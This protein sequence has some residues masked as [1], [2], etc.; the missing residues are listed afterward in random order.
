VVLVNESARNG[1]IQIQFRKTD[2]VSRR[3]TL[4]SPETKGFGKKR[5]FQSR[6]MAVCGIQRN[7]DMRRLEDS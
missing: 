3:P 7:R 1:A 6:E 5:T 4:L 2:I